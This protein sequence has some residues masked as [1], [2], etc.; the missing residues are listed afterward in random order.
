ML[1]NILFENPFLYVSIVLMIIMC[2]MLHELAHGYVA[3]KLGDDTPLREGRM[4]FN[5]MVNVGPWSMLLIAVVG[6]GWGSMPVDSRRLRG[7]YGELWVAGAG[8]MANLLI[9]VAVLVVLVLTQAVYSRVGISDQ[10]ILNITRFCILTSVFNMALF[11]FNLI[12]VYPLDG[13]RM[14]MNLDPNFR[15]FVDNSAEF[16]AYSFWV[17]FIG[18]IILGRMNIGLF[19]VAYRAVEQIYTPLHNLFL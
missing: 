18:L 16:R 1:I 5:P 11:I 19:N 6:I 12:P 15:R 3:I 14:L 4:T 9:C 13:C 10:Q 8:P 2:F 7:R 17:L